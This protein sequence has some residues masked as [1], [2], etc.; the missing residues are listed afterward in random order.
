LV[1]AIK[2][3][4]QA[5]RISPDTGDGWFYLANALARA[6]RWEASLP[7]V[8]AAEQHGAREVWT[9]GWTMPT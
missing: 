2:D 6:E 1:E 8:R 9:A 3:L 5:V 4:E 7:G